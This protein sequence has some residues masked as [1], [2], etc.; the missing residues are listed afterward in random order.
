MPQNLRGTI[1]VAFAQIRSFCTCPR[2]SGALTY[3][4][5]GRYRNLALEQLLHRRPDDGIDVGRRL[6]ASDD[7]ARPIDEE[8]G[9]VPFDVWR[10]PP[11]RVGLIEDACQD[12]RDPVR[13]V[14]AREPLLLL[15][16]L[17]EGICPFA[18]DFNLAKLR[19][20]DAKATRAE[21]VDLI[22]SPGG[23]LAK[24]IAGEVEDLEVLVFVPLIELL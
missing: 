11:I 21:A 7:V 2:D 1:R 18:V 15:E 9:E 16:P 13:G 14:K 3:E 6:E 19:K 23:L 20:G 24:L 8:L 4:R 10:E 22:G 12:R 5:K 17:E